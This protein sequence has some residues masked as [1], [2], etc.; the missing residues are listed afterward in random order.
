MK[1]IQLRAEHLV[2]PIGL[3]SRT[4]VLSWFC[5]GGF[6]Q[7]A[8]RILARSGGE[9]CWDSGIVE[10]SVMLCTYGKELKARERVE[11]TLTL[12]DEQGI[13]GGEA[14]A[15][16][17]AALTDGR[18][19]ARWIDPELPREQEENQERQP[20][21]VLKKQFSAPTFTSARLYITCHGLYK[22]KL[23]G[24]PVGDFVLAPGTD[25]YRKRLQYQTYDVTTLLHPGENE[26]LVTLG[27]GWYRGNI[28]VDGLNHYYGDDLALLCQLECDGTEVLCS[29]ETWQASQAGPVRF[30]DLEKG[31]EYDACKETVTDWHGVTVK[32]YGYEQLC[33]S[34]SV[35]VKEQERFEGKLITTPKGETV[36]DF[37]QNLAGYVEMEFTASAGD[38]ITL[39]HGETLDENGNFTQSNF[40]PGDRNKNGGIPQRIDYIC[41]DGLN[42]YKPSFTIFGFR[43]AK[44]ETE[45]NLKGARFTAIA[46]YSEMPRTGWFECGNEAVNRLALNSLWSMRSN[47]VDIPTDCPTRERAGWTGDAG[48]FAETACYLADSYPIYR[49]WLAECRLAQ[50]E[51]GL[52]TNIAPVNDSGSF[53]SNMLQGSAGWGDACVLV[54]WALYE[55][56]GDKRILEENY[57]MMTGWL[58]FVENRAGKTRVQNLLNPYKKYLVDEGFH[59]GEWMEPDVSSMDT[60]KKNMMFGAPEVAT[61]YFYRSARLVSRIARLLGRQEDA[62]KY[63][64]LAEG[65]RKAYRHTCT[66]KGSIDSK[67]QAEYVRPM[68]FGLLEENEKQVAADALAGLV[69]END[70]HLNTGFLSTPFLCRALSDTG[71]VET[72]YRLLL[73]DSCPGWLYPVSKGATT[74]WECWDGIR[75]DGTVHDSLNHYSYG[76]ICGWLFG[77]VCGIRLR[78]GWAEITPRPHPSLEY[79]KAVWASPLGTIES[80][81]RYEKDTLIFDFRI[82]SNITALLHLPDGT[83]HLLQPGGHQFRVEGVF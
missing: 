71:H 83:D 32:D 64:A 31:E 11:W 24:Q 48:V 43:Y 54:P 70:Y 61:A 29:D 3:Q 50:K 14:S 42:V 52:V 6:R 62:E 68:V 4:P 51:D 77:D 33:A 56:Y 78:E 76:A 10:S 65:A 25:D 7:T 30:N 41:K 60:M 67:R 81:W 17:E 59:F 8:Y 1:G 27:D 28:G 75:E 39:W 21:S 22:A 34:D 26:F 45:L 80:S 20:A 72:A 16:F 18:W 12:R 35:S 73:Q 53:I 5:Q 82:P 74:I 57:D 19:K 79:A 15:F 23:N 40:D 49:K 44:I 36:I 63:A 13:W 9:T 69:K 37:G 66:K 47:F 38:T 58:G 2:D 46:V 55:V